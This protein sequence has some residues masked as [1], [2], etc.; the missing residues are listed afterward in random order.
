MTTMEQEA[1]VDDGTRSRG[2]LLGA[3]ASR[4]CPRRVHN[5]HDRTVPKVDWVAAPELQLRLDAG[6]EFETEVLDRLVSL[7]GTR[8]AD[9]RGTDDR[10]ALTEATVAAMR[11]G[12]ALVVGGRLPDD[13]V[14]ARTGRPDVLLRVATGPDG[15]A[16]R[17]V[18]VEVKWHLG[19]EKRARRDVEVSTL[20]D[21]TT[22]L[23]VE[24]RAARTSQRF[25]DLLQLAHYTRLLQA[26]GFHAGDDRL[27]AAVLGTDRIDCG[28]GEPELVLVWHDLALP[29]FTT[30]SR[31][32][33]S[34]KRSV[35][36]RYDHEHA[37]RVKVAE[38]ARR[39]AG[40]PDDPEPL[41][42]PVAQ[43]ECLTCPYR[44]WCAERMGPDDPSLAITTGRLRVREWLT[45]QALGVTSTTALAEVDLDHEGFLAAFLA[46]HTHDEPG[47]ARRLRDAV[48]RARML[49]DGVGLLRTG[50]GPLEVPRADVEIDLDYES[51]TDGRRYLWGARVARPAADGAGAGATYRAF[52]SWEPLD[53]DRERSLA[54]ELVEW[55]RVEIADAQ[56][57]G[58]TLQVHHW[59]GVE[60]DALRSI[61]GADEVADVLAHFVDLHDV[62]R[63]QFVGVNGLGLK[64][65]AP[66]LGFTW[67]DDDA[68]GSQSQV[69]L[70]LARD[71]S[72]PQ[73]E[74][75]RRRVLEYNQDDVEATAVV[76]KGLSRLAEQDAG[77]SR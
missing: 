31:S 36:E 55:L 28:A 65:V 12:A 9:L 48:Q 24:G 29:Q 33:G 5:D 70:Q 2:P 10:R 58:R 6:T 56:Q 50:S 67:R 71:P 49:R 11:S 51:D 68:G 13:A 38:V 40:A 41:V 61:L 72:S 8:C 14:G 16:G 19:T 46:E 1:G 59:T 23:G 66:Q 64:R 21:P 35:L 60:P 25:D 3:H 4:R 74:A 22:R 18:P 45:L 47:A 39:R 17:Y 7:H 54:V 73:H 34:A 26:C 52:V 77:A 63:R 53:G 44:D 62:V 37:F 76:R 75:M 57:R 32:R 20:A 43:A 15:V 69:W 42:V 27:T 30:F